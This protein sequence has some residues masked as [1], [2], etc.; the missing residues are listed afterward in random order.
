MTH[1]SQSTLI[2]NAKLLG[3]PHHPGEIGWLYCSGGTIV[4]VGT[5]SPPKSH[6][7]GSHSIDVAQNWVSP[8]FIDMHVHG[9]DGLDVMD[10]SEQA[11]LGIG[12]F[13]AKHGTTGWLPTTMTASFA[14]TKAAVDAVR[15]A[16]LRDEAQSG[17]K[18][19]G[20]HLE[21][22]F[23]SPL[24]AGAQNPNEIRN[25]DRD[26]L[27]SLFRGHTA[28][29]LAKVTIA[30]E[31]TGA[32]EMIREL[33]EQGVI[34]SLG[35]TNATYREAYEAILAGATHAT[36]MYNAMPSIHHREGGATLA[37]LLEDSVIC[38]L[39]ADGEHVSD[40]AIKLLLKVKGKN[41]IS[42]ITDAM[43]ATGKSDGR[44]RFGGH[45]V[46]VRDGR[47]LLAGTET[48]A[49]S[50]L[51]LDRALFHMVTRIGVPLVEAVNMVSTTPARELGLGD[52]L[53]QIRSGAMADLVFLDESLRVSR[54][55]IRG[56]QVYCREP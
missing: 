28:P 38:E 39:I 9:G 29:G 19:L 15:G 4:E 49:G 48:L 27:T 14:Q 25:P 44:Y 40:E 32:L 46:E 20:I 6:L 17:A 56:E 24:K 11:I 26:F 51:T 1:R 5:G 13:H 12:R 36:H 31:L 50:T 52:V 2:Y 55:L 53:G 37:C 54:T 18:I 35:H 8:G 41:R 45:E 10:G 16:V 33:R 3:T 30:P 23:I 42:L 21:G 47:P 22:P 34:V 43:C 7:T